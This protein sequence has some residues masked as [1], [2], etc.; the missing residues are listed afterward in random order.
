[1]VL[2][3]QT[4]HVL[5]A[6]AVSGCSMKAEKVGPSASVQLLY[7]HENYDLLGHYVEFTEMLLSCQRVTD[8]ITICFKKG[9]L[10]HVQ[11]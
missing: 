1:V 11:K 2:Q 7:H 6:E 3:R 9:V 8:F 10:F 4:L 5:A